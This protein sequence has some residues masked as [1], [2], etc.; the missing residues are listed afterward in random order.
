MRTESAL[1]PALLAPGAAADRAQA[2]QL[3]GWLV[4]HWNIEVQAFDAGGKQYRSCGEIHAGW[5]LEGRAIQDVWLIPPRRER[6][7]TLNPADYP[8]TG[9][10]YGT[11]LRVC[12]P[13]LDAWHIYWIDPVTVFQARMLGR[14]SGS[15]IVQEG[16]LENGTRLRWSFSYRRPESFRWTGEAS[17]DGGQSWMLQV[18]IAARRT[19]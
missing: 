5:V 12:P 3:Y 17:M 19:G 2:L 1:Q 11:T 16:T 6:T 18:D 14:A 8:V 15:D 13:Q 9:P 10:W 7:A 4:G